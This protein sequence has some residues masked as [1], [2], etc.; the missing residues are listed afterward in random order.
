MESDVSEI[1]LKLSANLKS[2]PKK[3]LREPAGIVGLSTFPILFSSVGLE[4]CASVLATNQ[5]K[6]GLEQTP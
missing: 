2:R 5:L 1:L 4:R 6:K 3:K